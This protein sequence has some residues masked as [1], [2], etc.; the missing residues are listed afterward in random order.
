MKTLIKPTSYP[1]IS[2]FSHKIKP[3]YR[4]RTQLNYDCRLRYDDRSH[5][6]GGVHARHTFVIHRHFIRLSI[7]VS[8][9]V[10]RNLYRLS[11]ESALIFITPFVCVIMPPPG[12]AVFMTSQAVRLS[13]ARVCQSPRWG[14]KMMVDLCSQLI[15]LSISPTFAKVLSYQ[16][17]RSSA[18][19]PHLDRSGNL[20]VQCLD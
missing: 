12:S 19:L 16:K 18:N 13:R 10:R 8:A 5:L 2:L 7:W 15:P 14:E 3:P 1:Y 17:N 6:V 20:F 4:M 9:H 11:M